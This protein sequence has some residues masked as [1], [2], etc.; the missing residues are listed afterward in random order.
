VTIRVVDALNGQVVVR[1]SFAT[2]IELAAST[3]APDGRYVLYLQG[4]NVASEL[5][6]LDARHGTTRAVL[7]PHNAELAPFAITFAFAPSMECVAITLE[8]VFGR[9]PETWLVDLASGSTRQV[10]LDGLTVERW[11]RVS[12]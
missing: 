6:V 5:T 1:A 7:L 11:V 2:R 9:G 12:G 10:D 3:S 4:N 8:R